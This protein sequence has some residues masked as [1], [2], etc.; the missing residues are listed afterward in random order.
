MSRARLTYRYSPACLVDGKMAYNCWF[1]VYDR[2]GR[3]VVET[4]DEDT[5]ARAAAQFAE[6]VAAELEGCA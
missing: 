5:A 3:I 4:T 1:T 6:I 2:A